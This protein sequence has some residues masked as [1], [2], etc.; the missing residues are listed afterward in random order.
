MMYDNSSFVPDMGEPAAKRL[1][2]PPHLQD[3]GK[4]DVIT[5]SSLSYQVPGD[6][7]LTPPFQYASQ[8]G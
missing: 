6:G 5:R 4:V 3:Y 1:Y 8:Q 2:H 7:G